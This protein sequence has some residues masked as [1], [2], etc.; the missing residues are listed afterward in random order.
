MPRLWL[1]RTGYRS[2]ET[3]FCFLDFWVILGVLGVLWW[4]LGIWGVGWCWV[5][6][7]DLGVFVVLGLLGLGVDVL[8]LLG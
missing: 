1:H 5:G 7:W 8:C 3:Y 6:I 4:Y 2:L